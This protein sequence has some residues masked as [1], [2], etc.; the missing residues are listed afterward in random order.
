[1]AYY[2]SRHL[3]SCEGSQYTSE[4][5]FNDWFTINVM[6]DFTNELKK[7]NSVRARTTS[8]N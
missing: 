5:L 2:L 8:K 4:H 1:M 6:E 3:S 7:D